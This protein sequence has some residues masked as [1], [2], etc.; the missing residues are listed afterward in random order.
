MLSFC[1][2]DVSKDRLDIM[3]LPNEQCFSVPNDEA[4]WATLLEQLRATRER[5]GSAAPFEV[6]VIPDAPASAEMYRDLEARGVTSTM[7]FAFSASDPRFAT[8]EAK[9]D[10]LER[11][12]DAFM[13]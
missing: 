4:G 6:F 9:R 5:L 1:G 2:I 8:L 7:A 11:F 3:V 13:R 12:A 10:A